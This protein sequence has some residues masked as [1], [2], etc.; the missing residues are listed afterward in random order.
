MRRIVLAVT[1][2]LLALSLLA[3]AGCG[4]KDKEAVVDTKEFAGRYVSESDASDVIEIR[5]NSTFEMTRGG[6]TVSG[7]CAVEDA[8]LLLSAGSFSETMS[9]AGD[10]ITDEDGIRYVKSTGKEEKKEEK[11]EEEPAEEGFAT[12]KEAIVEYCRVNGIEIPDLVVSGEKEVSSRDP[13]WEVDYA[14]PP[15][16]EGLGVFFLLHETDG[17]WVVVAH[18]D[19]APGWTE[20]E[21]KALGAPEDLAL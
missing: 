15:E 14:F 17:G 2:L 19:D 20:A 18:T 13:S 21:L 16:A 9:I 3:L 1:V 7:S 4:D 12:V 11:K 5:E 6:D 8:Q 10:V